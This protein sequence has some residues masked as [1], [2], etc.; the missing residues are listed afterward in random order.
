MKDASYKMHKHILPYDIS[1]EAS[2]IR[3]VYFTLMA[4]LGGSIVD[5]DCLNA[6]REPSD[7]IILLEEGKHIIINSESLPVMA[8]NI[9]VSRTLEFLTLRAKRQNPIPVS[10]IADEASRV[11]SRKSD[12]D[13]ILA[14]GREAGVSLH[15]ATQAESQLV[16]M[17]GEL[18]FHSMRS[19]FGDIYNLHTMEYPLDKFHYHSKKDEKVY[20]TEPI[21]IDK[22]VLLHTEK[23]YQVETQQYKELEIE[24]TEVVIYDARL[25]EEKHLLLVVDMH[26]LKEREVYYVVEDKKRVPYFKKVDGCTHHVVE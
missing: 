8:T 1:A 25:Y 9:I 22:K 11:M 7:M 24:E 15:L 20:I 10:F 12:L 13:R 21:F 19:N 3:G 2:G 17:Y 4:S 18:K 6:S 26:T 14:F 23:A 5:V 16:E